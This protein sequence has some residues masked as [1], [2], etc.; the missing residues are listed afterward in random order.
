MKKDNKTTESIIITNSDSTGT[1]SPTVIANTINFND[2]IDLAEAH[3]KEDTTWAEIL[4]LPLVAPKEYVEGLLSEGFTMIVGKPKQ[5][6]STMIYSLAL[7]IASGAPAFNELEV[8]KSAVAIFALETSPRRLQKDIAALPNE[9]QEAFGY[10]HTVFTWNPDIALHAGLTNF[11]RTHPTVKVIF[12]DTLGR[13]LDMGG[14][15]KTGY[16]KQYQV[17]AIIKN[18]ADEFNVA[19]VGLH[20]LKK[21]SVGDNPIDSIM[22]STGLPAAADNIITLQRAR[23]TGIT[24]LEVTG[25]NIDEAQYQLKFDDESRTFELIKNHSEITLGRESKAVLDFLNNSTTS[26]TLPE[27][28]KHLQKGKPAVSNLLKTLLNRDL[29][30]KP[31]HGIYQA[32]S[33]INA[34]DDTD[35]K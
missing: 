9:Y 35:N 31:G 1:Q 28:Q 17:G 19:I 29:I 30:R 18:V 13:F 27:I 3:N 10:I 6:K 12:I 14:S 32:L 5:G 33:Q 2:H 4:K 24:T 34:D 26:K 22:G 23:N 16:D 21:G 8:E 20:H 25:R 11:L 15:T 7:A